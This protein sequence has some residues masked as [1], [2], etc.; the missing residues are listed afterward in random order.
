MSKMESG[1]SWLHRFASLVA[2]MTFLLFMTGMLASSARAAGT[3]S[4]DSPG[5]YA[6][7]YH[8]LVLTV[9]AL[10]V[11]LV[12]WL[13]RSNYERYLKT[14]AGITLGILLAAVLV[15]ITLVNGLSP[16]AVSVVD[17]C[18]I[19]VF[20]C[21]TVCLALFTR[22]DWRWDEPKTGDLASPSMRQ[23]LVFAT[24]AIFLQPLLGEAFQQGKLGI[25]P[26]FVLGIVV[27]LCSVWVLEMALTK[28]SHLRSFK[29]ST[30][31]LAELVG[32][33]LFLGIITY[34][35][36]LNARTVPGPQP[37]LA[38]MNVTHAAVGALVLAASLF[39]TF[40]AFK[41]FAP[42]ERIPSPARVHKNQTAEPQQH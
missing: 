1:V 24:A 2:V 25:T 16:V 29:I 7:I 19:Q 20:F 12:V 5:K 40:Q 11:I 41:Y 28:F 10:T 4:T 27:T 13:S 42:S 23:I 8:F 37:G 30:I 3:H 15:G 34:S 21:L 17:L 39:V 14:L 35:M 36:N 22:T 26:H 32:L 33:E 9:G 18:G 31:F 38:V 6:S